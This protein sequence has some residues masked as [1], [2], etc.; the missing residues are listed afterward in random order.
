MKT[1]QTEKIILNNALQ[2]FN[3]TTGYNLKIVKQEFPAGKKYLVDAL[4]HLRTPE[5]DRK[6]I[7]EVKTRLTKNALGAAMYQLEKF[8]AKKYAAKK[9][10]VADYVNPVMAERL[11][12]M[13]IPFIDVAGNIYLNEPPLFIFVKGNKQTENHKHPQ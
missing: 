3:D 5:L 8:P 6:F 4:L 13:N 10:L 1:T 7:V 2:K 12:E 9:M 11:K